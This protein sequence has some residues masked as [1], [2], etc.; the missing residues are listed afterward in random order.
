MKLHQHYHHHPTHHRY[1]SSP[2]HHY[3]E[4]S[5]TR[6]SASINNRY[7]RKMP[8]EMHGGTSDKVDDDEEDDYG[9]DERRGL[10]CYDTM[11]SPDLLF[12][13]ASSPSFSGA[14]ARPTGPKS[15]LRVWCSSGT[16]FKRGW[17]SPAFRPS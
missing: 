8:Q 9:E 14:P 7:W 2:I 1:A 16:T 15:P 13:S 17:T 4:S 12:Y 11:F 10:R 3:R 5:T 6:F